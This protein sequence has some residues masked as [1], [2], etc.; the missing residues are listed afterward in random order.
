MKELIDGL[1]AGETGA[2]ERA[3]RALAGL[4]DGAEA[5]TLRRA[6]VS[7][8]T[9]P[10]VGGSGLPTKGERNYEKAF[11]HSSALMAARPGDG[12]Q[13]FMHA[14]LL[15]DTGRLAEAE[16]LLLALRAAAAGRPVELNV[17][18]VLAKVHYG[19]GAFDAAYATLEETL[20][21]ARALFGAELRLEH[22]EFLG[23][24]VALMARILVNRGEFQHAAGLVRGLGFTT[25]EPFLARTLKRAE[26]LAGGG[27]ASARPGAR[28]VGAGSLAVACVKYGTKYGPDYVNRLHRMV[29]R[30]LPG[31]WPFVC[32]TERPE[33]LDP[34]IRPIGF[35]GAPLPGWWAK[36][37]LFDPAAP[38]GADAVLYLDLD[39]VVVGDLSFVRDLDV[40]FQIYEHSM[41]PC[42]N[43]SVMVFDRAYAAPIHADFEPSV[44]D[45]LVS[46]Q[47]WI[48]ERMPGID[49]LAHSLVRHYRVLHPGLGAAAVRATGT[50]IV[51]FPTSPK[52][53]QVTEGWV[54]E[55][56][57]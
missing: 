19:A 6:L 3:E 35:G 24:G 51:T 10:D 21:R 56:W 54:P 4:G 13:A 40:G 16:Q 15:A 52:P 37:A 34:A 26:T 32:F 33:G 11:A 48:E 5:L 27:P 47:D 23:A 50:R 1:A 9:R 43:S 29:R 39:S 28:R 12:Q 22:R 25:K 49:T 31:D 20:A 44:M 18:S 38:I 42:F 45:R 46:D 36:I 41:E 17:L 30:H 55:L 57:R 8:Y 14:C 7:Y 53:H 2:A